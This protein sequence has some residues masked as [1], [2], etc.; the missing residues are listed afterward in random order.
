VQ[1]EPFN[2]DAWVQ[3]DLLCPPMTSTPKKGMT[4]PMV[5]EADAFEL[6]EEGTE[7]EATESSICW[8]TTVSE[9]DGQVPVEK[10][11]TFLVF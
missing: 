7:T 2:C 10:Q 3:C 1:T 4:A 5:E 6:T 8:E 11:L 9:D